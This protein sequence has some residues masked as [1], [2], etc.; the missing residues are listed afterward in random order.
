[1][2]GPSTGS[3]KFTDPAPTAAPVGPTADLPYSDF[4]YLPNIA[5][6]A[7]TMPTPNPHLNPQPYFSVRD[8]AHA[9]WFTTRVH[10]APLGHAISDN[11]RKLLR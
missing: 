3:Y 5:Q 11:I 1:M 2:A 9:N 8:L 4:G 7:N 10:L 6:N